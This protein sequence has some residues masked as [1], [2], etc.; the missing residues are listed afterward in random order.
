MKRPQHAVALMPWL[1]LLIGLTS[2]G[3]PIRRNE[4]GNPAVPT[5]SATPIPTVA[6]SLPMA[7]P[8]GPRRV[9]TAIPTRQARTYVVQ[10]G[11]TLSGIALEYGLSVS[12][13]AIANRIE[14][15]DRIRVGQRLVI[16]DDGD[17][18]V[19]QA[20]AQPT[21]MPP[22]PTSNTPRTGLGADPVEPTVEPSPVAATS[23]PSPET[24]FQPFDILARDLEAKPTVSPL[25]LQVLLSPMSHE[26]Q[27][28][29]NCAPV[30]VAMALSF[31]GEKLTQFDLAPVLKGADQ[32]RNVSPGEIVAYLHGI[33][34]GG[35][36]RVNGDIETVQRLVANGIPV[37]V[38]QWLDRP[39]DELTGHYRLVRGY[40]R[41]AEVIIV[42]DSYGGPELRFSHSEFDRLWRAFNR[43]YIPVYRPEQ[44]PLVREIIGDDWDDQVMYRRA[45]A[46]AQREAQEISDLYAW[47]NL[48]D[49]YLGLGQDEEAVAAFERAMAF[50]L[51]PRLL[52]YRFGPFEAYHRTGQYQKMLDLAA[53]LLAA[54]SG[55]EEVQYYQGVAYEGLGRLEEAMVAYERALQYNPR[56]RLAQEALRRLRG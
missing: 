20:L 25:P 9:P 54:V 36:V 1:F 6:A 2:C 18:S 42:N 29:N 11:D 43:L 5:S 51:P 8:P 44:E 12:E 34:F 41:E 40:D 16:P 47:F 32:D 53:P 28:M 33:R 52:W 30:T 15:P 24:D 35:Q 13:L 46:T 50:G 31:F 48:G 39:N 10:P 26:W 4:V 7:E 45:L 56:F 17:P 19:A 49:I 23:V 14:N 22:P 27:K 37:I 21:P 55:L 3:L 38:E